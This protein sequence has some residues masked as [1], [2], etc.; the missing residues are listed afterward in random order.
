MSTPTGLPLFKG[1]TYVVTGGLS[2]IGQA[3]VLQLVSAEAIVWIA[4]IGTELP[5]QL[6][7]L[8]QRSQIRFPCP[9]D[10]R[11]RRACRTLLDSLVNTHGRLDGLVNCAGICLPEGPMP[12]DELFQSEIEV[13][14]RGTW[15]FGTEAIRQMASQECIAG[16]QGRGAIVNIGSGASLRGLAGLSVYCMT[17]HAVLGLTRAWA[18]Q[19]AREG[20]RVNAVA[21]GE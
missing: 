21:P 15:N 7:E 11:D 18:Q 4:D 10:I 19:W 9:C 8:P 20:I 14:I 16:A 1:R 6:A 12:G 13:N 2:G 5:Q 3:V 17:K